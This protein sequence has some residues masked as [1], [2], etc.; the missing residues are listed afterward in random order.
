MPKTAKPKI[1]MVTKAIVNLWPSMLYLLAML[2]HVN[3]KV[4]TEAF[5]SSEVYKVFIGK[6][7]KLITRLIIQSRRA[8]KRA[9]AKPE[10]EKPRTS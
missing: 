3:L 8:A 1:R 6:T 4:N 9:G 2:A 7:T 10:R 5:Q